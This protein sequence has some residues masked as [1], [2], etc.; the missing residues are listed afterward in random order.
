MNPTR[1]EHKAKSDKLQK[2]LKGEAQHLAEKYCTGL[3]INLSHLSKETQEEVTRGVEIA[4][5]DSLIVTLNRI[6]K[7]NR[8]LVE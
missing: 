5:M 2:L 3:H 4:L 8:R 7:L 1:E 6:R